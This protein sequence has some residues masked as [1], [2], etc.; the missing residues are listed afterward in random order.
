MMKSDAENSS[1]RAL[2]IVI[3]D[4]SGQIIIE[5]IAALSVLVIGFA[6]FFGLL[7]Q[8][9]RYNRYVTDDYT[10]T[11]LAAEGIEVVK[12]LLDADVINGF[13]WGCGFASGDYELVYSTPYVN[14]NGNVTFPPASVSCFR[15]VVAPYQ[16]RNLLLDSASGLYTYSAGTATGFTRLVRINILIPDQ[17]IQVNSI[18]TWRQGSSDKS[19]NLEDRFFDW[20]P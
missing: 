10:G 20:Y 3:R 6:G 15:S 12:N 11:Y 19:V 14:T 8:S 1:C 13:T 5:A 17:E 9:L 18:V 4:K 16:S 2:R 7:S